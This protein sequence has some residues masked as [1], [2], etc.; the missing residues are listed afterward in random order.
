VNPLSISQ[1][2]LRL[3]LFVWSLFLSCADWNK[4]TRERRKEIKLWNLI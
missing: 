3:P 1:A 4:E 2:A